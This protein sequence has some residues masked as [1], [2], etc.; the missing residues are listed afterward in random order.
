MEA[1]RSTPSAHAP[2]ARHGLASCDDHPLLAVW[3][4][5]QACDLI[6]AH[7]RACATPHRADDEL[8]TTEG[9]H[10]LDS[11]AAMGTR[12]VVLTGGDPAKR[13]D[14]VELVRHGS[15]RGL[16]MAVTPSGTELT[17]RS[18]LEE[19]KAAGLARLAVSVDGP[20][21][22]VH[23]AFRGVQGSFAHSVRIL[24]IARELGLPTQVNTSLHP[25]NV[26]D[27]GAM[28]EFVGKMGA[29]LWGVFA[30][31]PTGRA[32]DALS[33]GAEGLERALEELADL[34][35]RA[36]F[37]VKTT[38]APHFRR[39]LMA[40]HA[41]RPSLGVLRDVDADGVVHGPRGIT[42]GVGFLFVSHRGDVFPSGFLPISAGNIR[43]TDVATIYRDSPLFRDLRDL[44]KLGG[45]CGACPFKR[46]C[47]G[48]RARAY[49]LL[50]DPLA[51]DPH[52]A[53]LPRGYTGRPRLSLPVLP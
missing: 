37:D 34:A 27:L 14:L 17:T 20:G 51:E 9:K 1:P 13:A 12:L 31:V 29:V 23:D 50:G 24:E 44:G 49:A 7:C 30:V 35:D 45:K 10:L 40:R 11:I 41:P 38:A 8:D 28:A 52:C 21:E 33:M 25:G 53:Y 6:C 32:T 2:L 22:Q 47:G 46:I 36:P 43:E 42:D 3:E 26:L 4:L 5:T 19:L 18:L 15:S 16:V 48:S 39:I